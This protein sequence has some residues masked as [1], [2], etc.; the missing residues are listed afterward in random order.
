MSD[1]ELQKQ[2]DEPPVKFV[3]PDRNGHPDIE[4]RHWTDIPEVY[5]D[6]DAAASAKY[7]REREAALAAAQQS[8][9]LSRLRRWIARTF[10]C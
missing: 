5:T 3:I 4:V 2:H 10:G 8:S 7:R 1:M 6:K 9:L